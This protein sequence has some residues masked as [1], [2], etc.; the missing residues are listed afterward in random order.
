[1]VNAKASFHTVFSMWECGN[2]IPGR[3]GGVKYSHINVHG[4]AKSKA[5]IVTKATL[6]LDAVVY[7]VKQCC[8]GAA[9]CPPFWL[10]VK[11]RSQY[12]D[13]SSLWQYC[14]VSV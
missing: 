3:G 2:F 11:K 4:L 7:H 9:L 6:L 13:G 10:C 12:N 1:M 5:I 8:V 14:K